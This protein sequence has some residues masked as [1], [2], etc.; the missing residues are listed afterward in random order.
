LII[1][2]RRGNGRNFI[3]DK[4]L[5]LI[6]SFN[7]GRSNMFTKY[8]FKMFLV[9]IVTILASA[10]ATIIH[11]TTQDIPINTKPEGCIAKTTDGQEC[12]TPCNLSLKRKHDH[13]ISIS[14][15]GYEPKS[16]KVQHV[17][18]GA[19]A[20]N[21]LAGG[22]IGWGVDAASGGQYRL[23]PE[24]VDI[25]LD[26]IVEDVQK[27]GLVIEQLKELEDLKNV[28]AITEEE[29]NT[30]KAK[31]L[32]KLADIKDEGQKEPQKDNDN[33]NSTQVD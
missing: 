20:G 28:G 26:P 4:G 33:T 1:Q 17:V 21:I 30:L 7:G 5:I 8:L 2:E 10:C 16:V 13:T 25:E 29:Y 3:G 15:D 27:P 12:T 24:T 19:V 32:N 18:S 6:N 14:K 31:L 11:G 23:V 9:L 22:L